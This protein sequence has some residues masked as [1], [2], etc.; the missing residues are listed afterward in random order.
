MTS[1]KQLISSTSGDNPTDLNEP[2]DRSIIWCLYYNLLR[3]HYPSTCSKHPKN[4]NKHQSTIDN[5]KL[6]SPATCG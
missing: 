6:N 5:N 3:N 4:T 1:R 2:E